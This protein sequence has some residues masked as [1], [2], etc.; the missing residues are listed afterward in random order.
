MRHWKSVAVAIIGLVLLSC[1]G[2]TKHPEQK[3]QVLPVS[4]QADLVTKA[5]VEDMLKANPT[6]VIPG[7]KAEYS[8]K[9]V[10]PD[11]NIDYTIM[12]VQP[13]PNTQYTVLFANPNTNH[14]P[15]VQIAINELLERL[16]HETTLIYP[17]TQDAGKDILQGLKPAN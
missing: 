1:C 10:E 9:V 7:S 17:E 3:P 14:N 8:I 16:K 2:C 12:Q 13:D 15:E 5:A 11:P 4:V 6:V